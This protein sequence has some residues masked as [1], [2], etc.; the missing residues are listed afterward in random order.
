MLKMVDTFMYVLLIAMFIGFILILFLLFGRH[1]EFQNVSETERVA[2]EITDNLMVS[3]LTVDYGI[4]DFEK[5]ALL[6]RKNVEYVR[7]CRYGN[8]VR[9]IF[10]NSQGYTQ[11]SPEM[12]DKYKMITYPDR[13]QSEWK[14]I[15]IHFGY[16]GP[17]IWK[18]NYDE[19]SRLENGLKDTVGGNTLYVLVKLPDGKLEFSQL[20]VYVFDDLLSKISCSI[21]QVVKPLSLDAEIKNLII[22]VPLS[23]PKGVCDYKIKP[24]TVDGKNIV[25]IELDGDEDKTYCRQLADGTKLTNTLEINEDQTK[26]AHNYIN[27]IKGTGGVQLKLVTLK[28]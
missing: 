6:N 28:D 19:I 16:F 13:P 9:F 27:V 15:S 4:F 14:Y 23:C 8:A 1:M 24:L 17:N 10:S 25:C 21:E 2:V 7:N 26:N 5:I 12:W 22:N 3:D 11:I 18:D 20:E